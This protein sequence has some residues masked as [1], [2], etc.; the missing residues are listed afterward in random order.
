MKILGNVFESLLNS[1]KNRYVNYELFITDGV[2]KIKHYRV[3]IDKLVFTFYG[4]LLVL[5]Y[6]RKLTNNILTH[7]VQTS[8]TWFKIP[9]CIINDTYEMWFDIV[10]VLKYLLNLVNKVGVGN[11]QSS[12]SV[13]EF[14]KYDSDMESFYSKVDEIVKLLLEIGKMFKHVHEFTELKLSKDLKFEL[15]VHEDF[16]FRKAIIFV[17]T[18][19]EVEIEIDPH[20]IAIQYL[21]MYLSPKLTLKE[22]LNNVENVLDEV[23]EYLKSRTV[24]LVEKV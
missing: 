9:K 19:P 21:K 6:G 22:F 23:I 7:Y 2:V 11:I 1:V 3:K 5:R 12:I 24:Y 20:Q 18:N 13:K 4:N 16:N 10:K 17:K 14:L 15:I 8:D